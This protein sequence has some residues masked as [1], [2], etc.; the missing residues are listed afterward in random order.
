[1]KNEECRTFFNFSLS[2]YHSTPLAFWRGVGGEAFFHSSPRGGWVGAFFSLLIHPPFIFQRTHLHLCLEP[3]AEIRL[4]GEVQI[5]RHLLHTLVGT[6]QLFLRI[7]EQRRHNP[8]RGSPARLHLHHRREIAH[9]QAHL[10]AVETHLMFLP[11][12]RA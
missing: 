9:R 10:I 5:F 2:T 11:V 3:L 12:V 7:R 8:M 6:C 1:M 4:A